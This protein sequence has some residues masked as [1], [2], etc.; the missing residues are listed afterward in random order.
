MTEWFGEAMSRAH[1]VIK[2]PEPK[3]SMR[4]LEFGKEN[5]E[6]NTE[7]QEAVEWVQQALAAGLVV[8]AKVVDTR[9]ETMRREVDKKADR[10][11]VE[12]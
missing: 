5:N 11:D 6:S 3:R 12:M 7:Q 1:A 10:I 9:L 4:A 8:F 2:S